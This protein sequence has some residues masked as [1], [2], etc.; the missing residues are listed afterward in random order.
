MS[1]S[2]RFVELRAPSSRWRRWHFIL[3]AVIVLGLLSAGG[4][5]WIL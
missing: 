1:F 2:D 3:L 4:G 5:V